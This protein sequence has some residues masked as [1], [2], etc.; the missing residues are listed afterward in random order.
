MDRA[1][2]RI[3]AE[4]LHTHAVILVHVEHELYRIARADGLTEKEFRFL[5]AR[6]DAIAQERGKI[7]KLVER[8]RKNGRH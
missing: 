1:D 7:T 5:Q 3:A 4:V 8:L 6:H 2:R